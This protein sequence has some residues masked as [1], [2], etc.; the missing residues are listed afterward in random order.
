MR[1]LTLCKAKREKWFLNVEFFLVFS[2]LWL[3]ISHWQTSVKM[4]FYVFLYLNKNQMIPMLF[5]IFTHTTLKKIIKKFMISSNFWF[6]QFPEEMSLTF[7][8]LK[9]WLLLK[10]YQKNLW[11]KQ[12][13]GYYILRLKEKKK[14]PFPRSSFKCISEEGGQRQDI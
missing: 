2:F 6:I 5:F 14:S 13:R 11:R 1:G 3:M 12:S 10:S 4:N 7:A 8:L 9:Q